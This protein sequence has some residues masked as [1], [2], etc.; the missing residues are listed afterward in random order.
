MKKYFSL[1]LLV[2]TIQLSALAQ[3]ISINATGALPN[4][5]AILDVS[6]TSKGFLMPRMTS[7][8]RI[9]ITNAAEG[10]LVYDTETLNVWVYKDAG[11]SEIKTDGSS[12]SNL[13]TANGSDIY[14]INS[15]NVGIGLTTPL[16]P[17]HIKN[18]AEAL[19]IQGTRPY[20]SFYDNASN[21]KSFILNSDNDL[22]IGMPASNPTGIMQLALSNGPIMTML[23]SGNVGIGTT[24]PTSKLDVQ[25]LN[26]SFGITHSG[27]GGNILATRMGGTSAGIGTFSNTNMR[28]F[29]N[30]NSAMF[31]NSGNSYVGL[32]VDFPANKLQV[33]SIGNTG[34]SGNDFAIGDGT[35][36]LRMYQTSAVS[37][38]ASSADILFW[39]KE[40]A[41]HVGINCIFPPGNKLQVGDMGPAGYNGNDIAFGNGSQATAIAQTNTSSQFASTSDFAF[42]PKYGTGGRVGINTG[43]PRAPLDVSYAI[44]I[45][46]VNSNF[47][48]GYL[49]FNN[50]NN[51][52]GFSADD[53]PVQN[54]SII[55][56]GRIYAK[57]FDAYS[58]ARIKTITSITNSQ[59]DLQTI[60]ALAITNYTMKDKVMYG[61][62]TFKKVIAQE[63]EKVYPQVVSKHTDFIPNVY[64]LASTITPVADGFLLTFKT[65]HSINSSAKKLQVLE[66]NKGMQ[67]Y[68]IVAIP[69]PTE[70]IVSAKYIKS[71]KVFVYGEEVDDFRTVDYEGLT[72]LN[73]SAT[74]ELSKLVKKQAAVIENLERRLSALESKPLPRLVGIK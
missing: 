41:G 72:T 35:N 32:G 5:S 37:L 14:N 44:N 58:D 38:I 53:N 30:G 40:K 51:V 18:N 24:T 66:E 11:W 20:F 21:L 39:P 43:T 42:L 52:T 68:D 17:L 60:N 55:A 25:T 8:Q 64:Q 73:I 1:L 27:E 12:N 3:N 54:V 28:I 4:P 65:K 7:A 29:A 69:S 36:A 16:A 15:G 26:N 50:A 61:N 31:I 33:G 46:S 22:Y 74:Q 34:Y 45:N 2:C 63:V 62:K 56:S 19:R 57:E 9:A 10:L 49:T 67:Q 48:Y 23:P 71:N 6:S 47:G 13:W 59:Q 70:V